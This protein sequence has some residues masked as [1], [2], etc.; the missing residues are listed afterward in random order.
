MGKLCI[1]TFEDTKMLLIQ[2][3]GRKCQYELKYFNS[4]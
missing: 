3:G 4:E 2:T 1:S